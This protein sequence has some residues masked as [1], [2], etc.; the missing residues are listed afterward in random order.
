MYN[1]LQPI[2]QNQAQ[3][4]I[5]QHLC[6]HMSGDYNRLQH[7]K[8]LLGQNIRESGITCASQGLQNLVQDISSTA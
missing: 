3:C 1:R 2:G 8:A 4:E 6:N 7:S 5:L